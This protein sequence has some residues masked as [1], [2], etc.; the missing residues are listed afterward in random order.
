[1]FWPLSILKLGLKFCS[2][3]LCDI[4]LS[5]FSLT[6]LAIFFSFWFFFLAPSPWIS[7]PQDCSEFNSLLPLLY[8]LSSQVISSLFQGFKYYPYVFNHL[9]Y[10]CN[11]ELSSELQDECPHFNV[12][13]ASQAK[14]IQDRI[15]HIPTEACLSL[16]IAQ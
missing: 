8:M 10:I 15:L 11:P 6:F 1:M 12:S 2:Q 16:C 5:S 4:P 3:N 13:Q 7:L 9:T 14:Y